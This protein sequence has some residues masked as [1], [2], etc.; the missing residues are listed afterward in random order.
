MKCADLEIL[1]CDYMD[2]TLGE[3]ERTRVE[4]H[5]GAC[6]GCAE[7]LRDIQGATAFLERVKAPEAPAELVTR[8]LFQSPLTA[9][10]R[11]AQASRGWR[12]WFRG[13]FSPLLQPRLAMGMAMTILSFSMVARV[14]N[15][16]QRNLT[17]ADLEPAKVWAALDDK[18]HRTWARAVKYYDN[19]RLVYEIQ[20]RLQ[21][22]SLQ[23]EEERKAQSGAVIEPSAPPAK[24]GTESQKGSDRPGGA[25]G[26]SSPR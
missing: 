18:L 16:P 10:A 20:G 1:L 21:Q 15:V 7:M 12:R 5:L 19:L 26:G 2:G 22:W 9:E 24:E 6:A 11:Q 23:E 25:G 3:S 17:M 14:A 4:A 8:I 13:W